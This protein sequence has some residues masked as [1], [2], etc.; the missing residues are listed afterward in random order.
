MRV[1]VHGLTPT[2]FSPRPAK[3]LPLRGSSSDPRVC[4]HCYIQLPVTLRDQLQSR[5][6]T[7]PR[8]CCLARER[9]ASLNQLR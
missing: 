9:C 7:W 2:C 6:I 4:V 1:R 3:H 8:F 5:V